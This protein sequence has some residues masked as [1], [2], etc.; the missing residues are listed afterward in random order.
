M[1]SDLFT[2]DVALVANKVNKI[3]VRSI[4]AS[5]VASSPVVASVALDQTGPSVF[6][7]FPPDGV[8][9]TTSTTDVAGRVSDLLSGYELL[10]VSV[11]GLP[12]VVDAGI[13]TNGTFFLP[14]CR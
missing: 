2:A 4:D 3:F 1:T 5:N 6:I 11:N 8:E 14:P 7:D 13:G 9:L 12:A 10:T